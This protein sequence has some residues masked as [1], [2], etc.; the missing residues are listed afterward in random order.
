MKLHSWLLQGI[1]PDAINLG[2]RAIV[3]YVARQLDWTVT[4]SAS[5]LD[6]WNHTQGC[7]TPRHFLTRSCDN[8]LPF[9][10]AGA[11]GKPETCSN[12]RSGLTDAGKHSSLNSGT[13][14]FVFL[15]IREQAM[16]Y[17]SAHILINRN[18]WLAVSIG[19]SGRPEREKTHRMRKREYEKDEKS[20]S[21]WCWRLLIVSCCMPEHSN[22]N[23]L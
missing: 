5:W 9:F 20:E 3:A 18:K 16:R 23:V 1:H 4:Q 21:E 17:W 8:S 13:K 7:S 6:E 11:C 22:A 14:L 19:I 10:G 12:P 15:C 2:N